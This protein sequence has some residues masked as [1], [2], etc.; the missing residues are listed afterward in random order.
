MDFSQSLEFIDRIKGPFILQ[1]I[2]ELAELMELKE[3]RLYYMS[4]EPGLNGFLAEVNGQKCLALTWGAVAYLTLNELE[5]LLLALL[6]RFHSEHIK[7]QTMVAT[8]FLG[9]F[10]F[11]LKA[12]YLWTNPSATYCPRLVSAP[13]MV[14]GAFG[15]T[16]AHTAQV[17]MGRTDEFKW[18]KKTVSHLINAEIFAEVLKKTGGVNSKTGRIRHLL[19]AHFNPLFWAPAGPFG[20]FNCHR[21]LEERVFQLDPQWDGKW[22]QLSPPPREMTLGADYF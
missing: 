18:D 16:I 11:Q 6:E 2:T 7:R 5:V 13:L 14:L 17:L 3:P 19:A 20:I 8:A 21:P 9:L 4:E 10:A 22:P 12:R 1:K 15:V